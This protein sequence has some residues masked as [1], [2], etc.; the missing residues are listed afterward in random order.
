MEHVSTIITF[1]K[2]SKVYKVE[3]RENAS[4]LGAQVWEGL[5]VIK[6]F[7]P[8]PYTKTANPTKTQAK[9]LIKLALKE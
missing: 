9:E 8:L 1:V 7:S 6:V 5:T 4:G 3:Y 2:G